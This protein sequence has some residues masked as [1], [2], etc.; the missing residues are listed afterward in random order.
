MQYIN[1]TI[2]SLRLFRHLRKVQKQLNQPLSNEAGTSQAER[3]VVLWDPSLASLFDPCIRIA[4][5]RDFGG[6]SEGFSRYLETGLLFRG[7]VRSD[8]TTAMVSDPYVTLFIE[9]R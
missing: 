1:N 4:D 6:S 3:Q 2:K 5:D 9:V 7:N 8:N